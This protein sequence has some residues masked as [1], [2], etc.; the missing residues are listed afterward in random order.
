MSYIHFF[1]ELANYIESFILAGGY[2][3]VFL[4]TA[5]EGIPLLGMLV[6]GHVAIVL[7]GFFSKLGLLDMYWTLAIALTGAI[8]GDYFGYFIGKK[9]GMPFIDR[10]RP[11]FFIKDEYIEKARNLLNKHTGKALLIGR[12]S[13]MTRAIMPFL[14]G[15]GGVK[16]RTF[17]F[18]NILGAVLWVF[19]SFFIGYIFGSGYHIA[20]VFFGKIVLGA[21]LLAILIFWGYNFINTRFHI[22]QKFELFMLGINILSLYALAKTIQDAWSLNSFMANFDVWVNIFIERNIGGVL[23]FMANIISNVGSVTVLGIVGVLIGLYLLFKKEYRCAFIM[24]SS[25][26]LT[27]FFTG[28]LKEL[29]MR[30]R[31]DNQ[32]LSLLTDPSFP[33]GHSAMAGAFFVALLYIILHKVESRFIREILIVGGVLSIVIIGVSRIV[34]NVHWFS[35]VLAGWALGI[36]IATFS[37]LF[38]RYVGVL[39]KR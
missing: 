13:P 39:V 19:S 26:L 23:I 28:V 25:V 14:V 3:F 37:V 29:F 38:V 16:D 22:F 33:S 11:Y 20:S 15:C 5:L 31:P 34:L 32:F 10:F 24:V 6:P 9:Y 1:A 17:W 30:L 18:Y 2:V 7:A 27:G 21:I 35:D 36:F 12:F 4:F 8:L